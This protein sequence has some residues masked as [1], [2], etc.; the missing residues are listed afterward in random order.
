IMVKPTAGGER[1]A[2]GRLE[3]TCVTR[4]GFMPHRWA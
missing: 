1:E 3:K 4:G 2:R